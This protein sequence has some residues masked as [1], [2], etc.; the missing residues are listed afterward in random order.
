MTERDALSRPVRTVL[1]AG[2]EG[3]RMG[4]LGTGRLKPLVPYGGACRLIDFSLANAR[5]SGLG[6][7]LLLSQYEE[8]QLMD[9]L[10]RVW[11]Q[12]P[13]F[14]VHFGPYDPAYATAGSRIPSELPART[15]PLER[16]TADALI[17]KKA[18]V[19]EGDGIRP[20]PEHVLVLHAD[21]VYRFDYRPLIDAHRASG[22]ALTLA[23]QRIDP[24]WVHLFGMVEF[25]ARG[26]LTA[27]VEKPEVA[28]SDLVFA[29]FC[30]FDA[31][32]L[33]RYLERLDGTDW[34]HDI[35]RDVIP[36]MLA[37]GEHIRGHEV[38]GH[39]E[40]IGTVE[41][42]H[43]AHLALAAS[44]RAGLPVGRMPWTVA[45]DVRRSWVADHFGVRSSVVPSD[46]VN[47]GRVEDSVLFPGVRIGAGARVR[48]SV[49]LPGAR[50]PAGADIEG[51]V[52]LEDGRVQRTE[53]T[54]E[55]VRA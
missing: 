14:R 45:P 51:A 48:R 32:V 17:R 43:R 26:R 53:V 30:V 22:A 15:W 13:G 33:R 40:D 8:R 10:H 25:D 34:Q 55:G 4:P 31:A 19:F 52:V 18:Y 42:Y 50:I 3:R 16:G 9:D 38:A 41:R 28:T 11:N 12:R 20:D 47:D 37:A 6:E 24:R 49:V 54:T 29:A 39:W 35:S 2:G 1:L 23:Y 46:L 7:V 21:H 36:A 27:F 44:P 5:A